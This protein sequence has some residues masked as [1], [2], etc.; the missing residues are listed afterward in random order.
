MKRLLLLLLVVNVVSS[1]AQKGFVFTENKGQWESSVLY[2]TE[3]PNGVLF[4]EKDGLTYLFREPTEHHHGSHDADEHKPHPDTRADHN[5]IHKHAVKIE[6]FNGASKSNAGYDP[7]SGY[8]NYFIGNDKSKWASKVMSYNSIVLKNIYRN[9][10]FKLYK[11][12]N[13]LKYEFILHPGACADDIVLKIIGADDVKV[14]KKEGLDIFTSLQIIH[15]APPFSFQNINGEQTEVACSFKELKKNHIVFSVGKYSRK[16]TLIIDPELVFS[17]YTGSTADNWG[18]TATYDR[19][20]NAFSGGIVES[21]GYPTTLGAYSEFFN[22]GNWDIGI[23]KLSSDGTKRLYATYLGGNKDE[24]PHSIIANSNDELIIFGTTGSSD[25]PTRN[26]YQKDFIG[27]TASDPDILYDRAISFPNGVDIFITK[28]SKDGSEV[29]SSTYMGGSGNDGLNF[30]NS[31]PIL[32]SDD[33]YYNYGD[34][35]RG[36]VVV[37]SDDNI[38]VGTCTFSNDF[39]TRNA[40]QNNNNGGQEGVFFKMSSDLSSLIVSSYYGGSKNDAIYSIDVTRSNQIFITGGTKS[41]DLQTTASAYN[42]SYQGGATDAFL[43]KIDK[44][45]NS[46][47]GAT[48]FGSDRYDQAHFVR[49]DKKGFP[50]IYGQTKATGTTLVYNAAYNTPNSGQFITKFGPNLDTLVWSTVFGIGNGQPNISPTAFSVDLCNRVYLSGSGVPEPDFIIVDMPTGVLDRRMRNWASAQGTKGM[51]VTP[52]AYQ[53]FTDGVDFYFM[54][55]PDDASYLDYAT[56]FGEQ[57]DGGYSQGVINANGSFSEYLSSY[58][59]NCPGSGYDHVDGG[60][61]RFDRKGN[62]Y[63]SVCASCWGCQGFPTDPTPGVWSSINGSSRCNNAV[64]KFKIHYDMVVADFD[65]YLNP[66]EKFE[67]RFKNISQIVGNIGV[68][69]HW[70]YGD[71]S[72]ESNEFEEVHQYPDT[73][74]Y[75]VRLIVEDTSSCNLIDTLYREITVAL[76]NEVEYADTIYLCPGDSA[77]IGIEAFS[78]T[79][80]T[81]TWTPSSQVQS[82]NEPS[83]LIIPDSPRTYE[84][85]AS[86]YYC[87]KTYYYPVEVKDGDLS[88]SL[89]LNSYD[90]KTVCLGENTELELHTTGEAELIR[91][92]DNSEMSPI[93][94]EGT[95]SIL[96][97][98]PTQPQWYYV[99]VFGKYCNAYDKDSISVGVNNTI[100]SVNVEDTTVC[101]NDMITVNVLALPTNKTYT[102]A[103]DSDVATFLSEN[104]FSTPVIVEGDGILEAHVTDEFGCKATAEIQVQ[105]NNLLLNDSVTQISCAGLSDGSIILNPTGLTP[106]QIEWDDG[107]S[108]T[109]KLNLSAGIYR[110]T[111]TDNLNCKATEIFQLDEP[112]AIVG[113]ILSDDIRCVD[114][115]N[116]FINFATTGGV[117]PYTYYLNGDI[118][119]SINDELCEGYYIAQVVDSRNCIVEKNIT[120]GFN[121]RLPY[122]KPTADPDTVLKGQTVYLAASDSIVAQYDYLWYPGMYLIDPF[123]SV[124]TANPME[125]MTYNIKAEDEYG[126][127]NF[128]EADIYVVDYVCDTPNIFIPNAFTPNNDGLNDIFKVESKVLT[129]MELYIYDRWG[130]LV[131]STTDLDGYWD[132]MYKGE[133]VHQAVF[134]YTLEGTCFDGQE[135]LL[136]GNITVIK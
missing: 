33:L 26:A 69:Y 82:P 84:L 130:E 109:Q 54:V 78:D 104:N 96:Q 23:L 70:E 75:T 86:S 100:L 7:I 76:E 12:D 123:V 34:G 27:D 79:S 77:Y 74:S 89:S 118:T 105:T 99:E 31:S 18:F 1:F 92:S 133:E 127:V 59:Y 106:I 47:L 42:P 40:I 60:T 132:G 115:C 39:P 120:I 63:Q 2:R 61:S 117:P 121:E 21:I 51:D 15:E 24:M 126:C 64:A 85:N 110:V 94:S 11:H 136:K 72:P 3:I 125:S 57:Y 29:L 17:S 9:I 66:C 25:F 56:F 45:G 44:N 28:L 65:Y 93:I 122:L 116:G 30:S 38:Y 37:D 55:L 35:A 8:N 81:Y 53:D 43:V 113:N 13:S 80:F 135:I 46:V 36:E 71:G 41:D 50:Y 111:L 19:Y 91:W 87:N 49:A 58:Y 6:F 119:D 52:N 102:V 14:N 129:E 83:T 131:F 124:A 128:G 22:G 112:S 97:I 10:D 103:W 73:G 107:S 108:N 95:D 16:K 114:I 62:I 88:A 90:G 98:A 5:N 20:G 134:V 68:K 32:Y 67:V 101:L 48:Y 4:I